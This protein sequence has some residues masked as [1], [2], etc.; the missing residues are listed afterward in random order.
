LRTWSTILR[1]GEGDERELPVV[2]QDL[3]PLSYLI[4]RV[5]SSA[6]S[7]LAT[8]VAEGA[9]STRQSG[10]QLLP[11]HRSR[12]CRVQGA[13]RA[14]TASLPVVLQDLVPLS[15]LIDR[16][17]SSAYSDLATLVETLPG[18]GEPLSTSARGRA[19]LRVGGAS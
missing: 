16:V 12:A 9:T 4:D 8:L 15:Y 19:T 6:Y 11:A 18:V 10:E 17:V 3:V 14:P 1:L 13:P 7:D 2:L 5:V